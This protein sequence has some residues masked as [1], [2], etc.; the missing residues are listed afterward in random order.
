MAIIYTY[1]VK[2]TPVIN[3]LLL[4]SDSED[5]NNTKKITVGS[6]PGQASGGGAVTS[7]TTT[8]TSGV[9][10]L[11]SGVLNIPNYSTSGSGIADGFSPVKVS[12]GTELIQFDDSLPTALIFQCIAD[13]SAEGIDAV[14]VYNPVDSALA[15]VMILS[16]QVWKGN[17]KNKTGTLAANFVSS[18]YQNAMS[19]FSLDIASDST[20]S[21]DSGEEYVVFFNV[22]AGTAGDKPTFLGIKTAS[23]S[24]SGSIAIGEITTLA[25]S[26][27]ETVAESL[28][29]ALAAAGADPN[30]DF[31]R[32][33]PCLQFYKK[34]DG[35]SASDGDSDV[36]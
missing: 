1:P 11:N 15:S 13:N 31:A 28:T 32:F 2:T 24:P 8:G 18:G 17:L 19:F 27:Q 30:S 4:I 5:D 21:I 10:T 14:K 33:R 16:I 34:G 6:L 35:D 3:D 22:K 20:L 23:G 26:S 12:L 9:S 29:A 36:G 7:L 25:G